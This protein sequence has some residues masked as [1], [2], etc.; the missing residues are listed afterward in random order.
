MYLIAPYGNAVG[1]TAAG[2]AIE[3]I[4]RHNAIGQL[5]PG[6]DRT[7]SKPFRH[8]PAVRGRS[9]RGSAVKELSMAASSDDC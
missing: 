7:G 1:G 8:P 5:R 2:N 3:G 6:T 9:S 4:A